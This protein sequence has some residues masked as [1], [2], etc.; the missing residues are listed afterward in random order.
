MSEPLKETKELVTFGAKLA[1]GLVKAG[2]DG[3]ITVADA[4]KF[5]TLIDDAARAVQGIEKVG[6]ELASVDETS[7]T[8]LELLLRAELDDEI[9][10]GISRDIAEGGL[11]IAHGIVRIL[12]GLRR[13]R[14]TQ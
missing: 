6:G 4:G 14:A 11:Q 10:D 7:M 5:L 12:A 3:H 13:A 8:E 1:E 2:E 9:P